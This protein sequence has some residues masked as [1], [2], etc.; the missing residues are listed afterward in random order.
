MIYFRAPG[1]SPHIRCFTREG[2]ISAGED[3]TEAAE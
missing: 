1:C 2:G 3:V